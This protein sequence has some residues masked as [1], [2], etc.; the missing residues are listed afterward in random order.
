MTDRQTDNAKFS[1]NSLVWGS[2]RLAPIIQ[3]QRHSFWGTASG[4]QLLVASRRLEV[5]VVRRL[6]NTLA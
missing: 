6:A 4:A 3:L 2:L 1:A 5:V